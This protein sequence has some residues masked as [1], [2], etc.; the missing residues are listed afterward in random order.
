MNRLKAE[1]AHKLAKENSAVIQNELDRIN[2]M[3]AQ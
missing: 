3:I 1:D 2:E